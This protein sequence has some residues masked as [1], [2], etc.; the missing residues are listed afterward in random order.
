MRDFQTVIGREARS[1]FQSQAGR[2][3][4]AVVA[5]VGGGS[6]AIGMFHPFIDDKDVAIYGVEAGGD[7]IETGRHSSTLSGGKPGVLHG[8]RTYIMQDKAGQVVETHSVS[9]GLDYAGVGPEHAFL[10]DSKRVQYVSVTDQQTLEAFQVGC[11]L[12]SSIY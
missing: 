6:N 11:R 1:Q 10:K 7:G 2:L 5:C 12:F 4:D 3:P 9:A 8:T